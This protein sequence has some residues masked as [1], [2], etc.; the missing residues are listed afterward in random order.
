MDDDHAI[1]WKKWISEL[2]KAHEIF[3]P[4]CYFISASESVYSA[5]LHAFSDESKDAFAGMIYFRFHSAAG[6][7]TS[8]VTSKTRVASPDIKSIPRLE[9]L[10][11]LILTRLI[12][13]VR[14]ILGTLLHLG[15]VYCWT[16]NTG[17]C[18]EEQCAFTN[19]GAEVCGPLFVKAG[20]NEKG[21]MNKVH[22]T[23]FTCCSSCAVHV[24]FV[25]DLTIEAFLHCFKCFKCF[26]C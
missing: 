12:A 21:Q 9:L 6:I 7:S 15:E 19:T 24:D 17:S 4:Q 10:S 2:R 8:L 14:R 1:I 16:D 11:A 23:L 18:L 26:N 3:L 5:Q 20:T 22:I 13:R 25:P